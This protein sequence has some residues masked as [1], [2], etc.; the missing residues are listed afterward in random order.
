MLG[1]ALLLKEW[2]FTTDMDWEVSQHPPM[3]IQLGRTQRRFTVL[4]PEQR[5][6]DKIASGLRVLQDEE[7]QPGAR[8]RSS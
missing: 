7:S 3:R 2:D 8:G 1:S 4:I 5:L 6:L